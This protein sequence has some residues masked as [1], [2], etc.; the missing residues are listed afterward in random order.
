MASPR[1]RRGAIPRCPS[2]VG[3][4]LGRPA[5]NRFARAVALAKRAQGSVAVCET[6]HR[7]CVGDETLPRRSQQLWPALAGV[8]RCEE[9]ASLLLGPAFRQSTLNIVQSSE[10]RA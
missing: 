3:R 9:C 1:C 5:R 7:H 8:F 4:S 10:S 2:T 6:T